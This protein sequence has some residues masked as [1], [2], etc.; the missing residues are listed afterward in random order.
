MRLSKIITISAATLL[1]VS[2]EKE[3]QTN[4]V[5]TSHGPSHSHANLGKSHG[6]LASYS[7][8]GSSE[9]A[10]YVEVKLH[11]DKGDIE[12]W[13]SANK[14]QKTPSDFSLEMKPTVTFRSLDNKVVTLAPRDL[15]DNK[16]EDGNPTIREGKTNY[17]IFPGDSGQ[18]PDFLKGKEFKATVVVA[19]EGFTTEEFELTPHTH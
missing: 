10:G 14:S 17:Y 4:V 12:L 16:D 2:C 3:V 6:I 1:F 11:D 8:S 5:E 18:S 19:F 7:A 13:M 9:V 15:T